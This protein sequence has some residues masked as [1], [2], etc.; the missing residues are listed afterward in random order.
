MTAQKDVADIDAVVA[1]EGED[2]LVARLAAGGEADPAVHSVD[3]LE[4][5]EVAVAAHSVA[6][7]AADSLPNAKDMLRKID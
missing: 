3:A 6:A 7:R 1:A 5:A 2:L 4:E